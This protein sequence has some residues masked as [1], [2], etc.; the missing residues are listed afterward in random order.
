M[1]RKLILILTLFMGTVDA[2][3]GMLLMFL[4]EMTLG[5]MGINISYTDWV[6]IRFVG[7]FVFGVGTS[8]LFGFFAVLKRNNWEEMGFVWK[9]TAWVRLVIFVFMSVSIMTGLLEPSWIAVPVT[10]GSV[11]LL[12]GYWVFIRRSPFLN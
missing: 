3:T 2:V 4:P 7:A 8:Y 12:Q 11:A 5:L 6:F 9:I 10:D 1:E